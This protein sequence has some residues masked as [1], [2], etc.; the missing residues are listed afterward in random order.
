MSVLHARPM[1]TSS[2]PKPA[3]RSLRVLYAEDLLQL[4]QL[5]QAMLA[6]IG[7]RLETTADGLEA[8]DRL[9]AGLA[10]FDLLMR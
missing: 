7:H 6:R 3:A 8:L 9:Q 10:D 4:R 1:S 2:T 5:M